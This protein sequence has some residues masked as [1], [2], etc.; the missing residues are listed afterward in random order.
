MTRQT[1]SIIPVRQLYKAALACLFATTATLILTPS[2][3]ASTII[4][5]E[6]EF[7]LPTELFNFDDVDVIF[8]APP[9]LEGGGVQSIQAFTSSAGFAINSPVARDVAASPADFLWNGPGDTFDVEQFV[10]AG[11][12]GEQ[13]LT[14]E[15]LLDGAVVFSTDHFI[16]TTAELLSLN[17]SGI[18]QLRINTGP[19]FEQTV[20]VGVL[21]PE[22][23]MDNLTIDFVPVPPAALLFLSGLGVLGWIKSRRSLAA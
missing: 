1:V 10:I 9:F 21:R 13:T 14:I 18:D 17:W 6:C 22:W 7:C 8:P 15:G 23:V 4:D 3:H 2:V 20:G 19:D 5:F 16:T 11:S 12:F